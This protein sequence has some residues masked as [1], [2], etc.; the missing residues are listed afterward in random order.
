[1]TGITKVCQPKLECA[2]HSSGVFISLPEVRFRPLIQK[3]MPTTHIKAFQNVA[4]L[5]IDDEHDVL[6][7]EKVF[8]E[9]SG[10]TVAT[11]SSG[12]EGLRLAELQSF[13]LVIVDYCM[14]EMGGQEFAIAM[15]RIRP[16]VAIIMLS[17]TVDVPRQALKVVD[18]FVGKDRLTS[19]LLPAIAQLSEEHSFHSGRPVKGAT[20][21]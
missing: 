18:A 15:R 14:P 4:L 10:Y 16:Q 9:T 6:A 20:G 17:G 11:A 19:Q 1:M 8:L 2:F 7:C 3:V 5:C 12:R 13:D 21:T